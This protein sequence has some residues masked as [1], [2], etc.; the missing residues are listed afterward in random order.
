MF[1]SSRTCAAS[2]SQSCFPA[3]EPGVYCLPLEWQNRQCR[4]MFLWYF[5]LA[6][7]HGSARARSLN[8]VC[9]MDGFSSDV[10]GAVFPRCSYGAEPCIVIRLLL[11]LFLFTMSAKKKPRI[12]LGSHPSC[13]YPCCTVLLPFGCSV[14]RFCRAQAQEIGELRRALARV[15]QDRH[16]TGVDYADVLKKKDMQ[17]ATVRYM[18]CIL[19]IMCLP[20][21]VA[22]WAARIEQG[23][24]QGA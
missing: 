11:Q 21:I 13:T 12:F 6:P 7:V 3:A 22:A 16:S 2:C 20:A 17:L 10:Q 4:F 8:G 19:F 15:T 23:Q 1:P 9:N 18:A 24:Q 5:C 14:H